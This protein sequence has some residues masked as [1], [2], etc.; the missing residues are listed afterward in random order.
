M[1][2]SMRLI[3]TTIILTM[4][5]QP[6]WGGPTALLKCGPHAQSGKSPVTPTAFSTSQTA[7][8]R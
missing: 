8:Y 3:L 7:S 4:L 2:I 5:A 1:I 6:V